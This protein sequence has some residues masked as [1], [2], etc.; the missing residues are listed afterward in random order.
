MAAVVRRLSTWE[1]AYRAKRFT[2]VAP[3][4]PKWPTA[5]FE[6]SVLQTMLDELLS[7]LLARMPRAGTL[8]VKGGRAEG[9][10]AAVEFV[11][12][13]TPPA[14][15]GGAE[16]AGLT[17]VRTLAQ[18]WGG[19]LDITAGPRGRGTHIRLRLAGDLR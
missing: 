8:V 2:I 10:G 1:P 14:S 13:G 4:G 11:C 17:L 3:D 19:G 5:L 16:Q 6:G 12:G 15:E 18:A 7:S 9:G